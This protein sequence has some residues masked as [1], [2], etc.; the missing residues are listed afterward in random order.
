MP[1]WKAMRRFFNARIFSQLGWPQAAIEYMRMNDED[2]SALQDAQ[3]PPGGSDKQALLKNGSPDYSMEWAFVSHSNLTNLQ[4]GTVGQYNHLTDEQVSGLHARSHA[5]T[6]ASDHTAANW[7]VFYSNGSG[8]VVELA[9]GASGTVLTSAGS[10]VAPEFSTLSVE[11]DWGYY[12]THWSTDPVE[13]EAITGGVVWSY[14]LGATTRYR[15]VPDPYD[16]TLDAF[17]SGFT[18]PTLSG[19]IVSRG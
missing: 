9:L 11:P 2:T 12:A 13:I 4:G 10:E 17:Y 15:F 14:T 19:L 5:V 16:P 6:S 18:S 3:I 1:K 7:R 8:E